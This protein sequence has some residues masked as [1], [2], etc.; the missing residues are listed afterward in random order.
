MK[1]IHSCST[2]VLLMVLIGLALF[3]AAE[4]QLKPKPAVQKTEPATTRKPSQV[5]RQ[6]YSVF[7]ETMVDMSWPEVKK[8]AE[9]DAVV[10]L[11]IAVI[12]EHGPHL[13][14]GIDTY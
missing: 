2:R 11:P 10:I 13:S 12:E 5:E 9:A 7:R 6:G 3:G 4:A 8:A 14:L 1:V